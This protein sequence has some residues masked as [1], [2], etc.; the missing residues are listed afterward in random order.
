MGVAVFARGEPV[1]GTMNGQSIA[2]A[3]LPRTAY[4]DHTL[5]RARTAAEQRSHR[6][7]TLEHLL[8]ALL[9]DPDATRLL[10]AAGADV[11]LI[12]VRVADTVN[13][14]MAPLV[15]PDGRTPAFSY[16][17]D[18]LFAGA[19]ADAI[20]FGRKVVDGALVLIAVA[21]EQESNAAVLLL[22]NGF[23]AEAGLQAI[24]APPQA[25][26]R[27]ARAPVKER[28]PA[29]KPAA[30]ARPAPQGSQILPN[31][32]AA[33]APATLA[34]DPSGE[35]MEDM[36]DSVRT[37][38]EAEERKERAIQPPPPPGPRPSPPRAEPRLKANGGAAKPARQPAPRAE[39]VFAEKQAPQTGFAEAS[40]P[41]FDLEKSPKPASR[42]VATRPPAPRKGNV[43]VALVAKA[44]ASIPRKTRVAVPET[45]EILLA[46]EE[47]G[48]IFGWLAR[49]GSQQRAGSEAAC[50]AIT[51]RLSAPGGGFFIEGLAPETQW[52]L[53]RP[54][55]LGEETFGTW[56]WTAIPNDS[57][58]FSLVVSMSAREVDANGVTNDIALPD[59]VVK[60]QV[61]GNF[62]RGFG[63]YAR[64]ALLLLAG[65][66]L[67]V[68][69][70]YALKMT[71]KFPQ[72]P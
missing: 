13:N 37:I 41:S 39:A 55:F 23:T 72:L 22:A 58:A 46:K 25:Q 15:V 20:R 24:G 6:Y 69:A 49:Q 44:L 29:P 40:A 21:R 26:A 12:R 38:L 34:P 5:R 7:V 59:Q 32:A 53:D 57:G 3:E 52:V 27:E 9:D 68:A 65:S 36:M 66:G 14:R 17:F 61:R 2:Y 33:R 62:W 42:A 51:L 19:A 31:G 60:V 16:K 43:N 67:T 28:P 63:R 48:L 56:A 70:Y 64:G 8:L 71:G 1:V 18:S 30:P 10:Q 47:A 35:S 54:A 4:L 45:I 11:S 50:R